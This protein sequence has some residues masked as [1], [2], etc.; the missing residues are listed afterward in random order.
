MHPGVEPAEGRVEAGEP[1]MAPALQQNFI[2]VSGETLRRLSSE[3]VR[4]ERGKADIDD[5]TVVQQGRAITPR[6][7]TAGTSVTSA[8]DSTLLA[9]RRR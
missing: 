4:A 8:L 3:H 2:L 7:V 6:F 1:V 5:A 9:S